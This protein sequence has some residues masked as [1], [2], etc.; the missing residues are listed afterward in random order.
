M[1]W[2]KKELIS[3]A[4]AEIAL[5]GYIYDLSPDEMQFALRRMDG[6]LGMWAGQGIQIGY[7]FGTTPTDTD[8]DADSGVAL[9]AVPAVYLNLA[10][11]IAAGKGKQL[12]QSSKTN[13]KTAYDA[14]LVGVAKQTLEPQQFRIDVPAGAG[15]KPW[16]AVTQP[17]LPPPTD[18]ALD[19]GSN[20]DLTFNGT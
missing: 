2:T 10:I 16:R 11:N 5:A 3:E 7:S 1:G 8:L 15:N 18:N 13:A 9:T 4:Y 14:M 20:G 17:F 12:A 19:V 6:M